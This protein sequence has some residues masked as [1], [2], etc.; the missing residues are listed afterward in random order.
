MND[1]LFRLEE[2]ASFVGTHSIQEAYEILGYDYNT[3]T[4]NQRSRESTPARL[5]FIDRFHWLRPPQSEDIKR[6]F[7]Q[8]NTFYGEKWACENRDTSSVEFLRNENELI[9]FRQGKKL[10]NRTNDIGYGVR[11]ELDFLDPRRH[12]NLLRGIAP[13]LLNTAIG[14]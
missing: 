4:K 8:T 1:H 6:L 2:Y 11:V 14:N 9:L 3:E 10:G 7:N 12:F 13:R 5:R